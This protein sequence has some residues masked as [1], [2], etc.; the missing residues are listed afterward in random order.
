MAAAS[1]LLNLLQHLSSEQKKTPNKEASS[2]E[3]LNIS[4]AGGAS[5]AM[6]VFV[7][8]RAFVGQK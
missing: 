6:E 4:S 1:T 5:D 8:L 2:V 7:Q 3:V